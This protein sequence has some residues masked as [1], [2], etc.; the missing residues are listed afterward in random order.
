VA[1]A[2]KSC[3]GAG[4]A[5]KATRLAQRAPP[6][7]LHSRRGPL[8]ALVASGAECNLPVDRLTNEQGHPQALLG[9]R[10]QA[11]TWRER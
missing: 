9:I 8:A 2:A 3:T 1:C 4:L 5:L 6:A 7:G 11:H 10:A